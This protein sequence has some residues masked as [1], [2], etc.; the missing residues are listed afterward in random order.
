MN[1]WV[2]LRVQKVS[3][4]LVKGKICSTRRVWLP[5]YR[6]HVLSG[7][8]PCKPFSRLR[9]CKAADAE[10]HKLFEV[11]FGKQGAQHQSLGGHSVLD[12][13]RTL[14]PAIFV[15][16]QVRSF[17]DSY[18]SGTGSASALR[19]FLNEA[20]QIVDPFTGKQ[21]FVCSRVFEMDSRVLNISRPR[22]VQWTF[23]GVW[24]PIP[25]HTFTCKQYV[26]STPPPFI[27][28]PVVHIWGRCSAE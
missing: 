20:M 12:A 1:Q 22:R 11:T 5:F 19:R 15:L 26:I 9:S 13:L 28:L 2:W 6:P 14:L 7:G 4:G 18:T 10:Y 16:E 3:R 21:H 17:A 8:S 24:T 27:P 23:Q 25:T